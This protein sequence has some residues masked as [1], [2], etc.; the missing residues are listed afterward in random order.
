MATNA[1][2]IEL[3]ATKRVAECQ[4][5]SLASIQTCIPLGVVWIN[6]V[7]GSYKRSN[8]YKQWLV[9]CYKL[10]VVLRGDMF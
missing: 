8:E 3:V 5:V 4:G 1:K 6:N 10:V 2:T 9:W 7:D